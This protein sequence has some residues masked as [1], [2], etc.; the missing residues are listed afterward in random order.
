MKGMIPPI[1]C[2]EVDAETGRAVDTRDD[3]KDTRDDAVKSEAGEDVLD[4]K[5]G[6]KAGQQK[7]K[8]PRER[9]MSE[10]GG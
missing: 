4:C 3:A 1:S 7:K 8:T 9:E 5:F 10:R 6:K 2:L